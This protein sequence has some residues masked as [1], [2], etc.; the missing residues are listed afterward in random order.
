MRKIKIGIS[1]SLTGIYSVQGRES[2]EGTSLWVAD[3]NDEGGIFVK[4]YGRKIPVDLVY[5]DDESS[6]QTCRSNT[7]RLISKENVDVVLGP[8]SSSLTLA[9]AEITEEHDITLWNHGGA[10]DEIEERGFKCLV[11]AITPASRYSEGIITLLRNQ[12]P[13]AARIAVFSALDSGFSKNIARGA[14]AFAGENG[15]VIKV[16]NFR[17]GR[18]DFSGLLE[19]ALDFLPDMILGAGRAR[20]DLALAEQI[21]KTGTR[22]KAVAL[23]AASV[24]LFKD[25][26]QRNADGFISCSQWESGIKITPDLGPTPGDFVERFKSAYGKDP[27]YVAAQGYNI[28]L[29]VQK[30]IAEAGTID[31]KALR[32]KG[33]RAEFKTFYGIFRTDHRGSQTGH[34]MVVVQ[35]QGGRK[36]IVHPEYLSEAGLTYP[37]TPVY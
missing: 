19:E 16:F 5:F 15:F 30:C 26:F 34:E 14:R 37:M 9:S 17:S 35:W 22:V 6:V 18:E 27:D 1:V 32:D 28:G 2:F 11:S 12:D 4:E 8:Y 13:G 20:D 36:M 23:V 25:T 24:K 7:E 10:T 33:R 29:I 21:I 31:D 3:V